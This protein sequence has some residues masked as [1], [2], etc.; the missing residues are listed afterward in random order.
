MV[1]SEMG[2]APDLSSGGGGHG[3]VLGFSPNPRRYDETMASKWDRR[4]GNRHFNYNF[5]LWIQI[6]TQKFITA[7]TTHAWSAIAFFS[8]CWFSGKAS[9][10]VAVIFLGR[11]EDGTES[12]KKLGLEV[13]ISPSFLHR[14]GGPLFHDCGGSS[15]NL[16]RIL[17]APPQRAIRESGSWAA[18]RR[19]GQITHTGTEPHTGQCAE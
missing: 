10:F 16:D 15:R 5:E 12:R 4:T 1:K 13:T 18:S 3:G 17:I 8:T 6:P 7:N 2:E 11:S 19:P 9:S 14:E